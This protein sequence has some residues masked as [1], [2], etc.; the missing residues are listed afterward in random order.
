MLEAWSPA[1]RI[2]LIYWLIFFFPFLTS[3]ATLPSHLN[4]PIFNYI[5]R[6]PSATEKETHRTNKINFLKTKETVQGEI[7]T[8]ICICNRRNMK[9]KI[10]NSFFSFSL[11][12]WSSRLF[13]SVREDKFQNHVRCNSV[14]LNKGRHQ[15][16]FNQKGMR[17]CTDLCLSCLDSS[18]ET[19]CQKQ[20]PVSIFPTNQPYYGSRAFDMSDQAKG[21]G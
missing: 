15:L 14:I 4:R 20:S 1:T 19:W 5:G 9:V 11:F 3:F 10:S 8:H 17:S 7:E 21:E 18:S 6:N 12:T 16:Y 13:A 2:L